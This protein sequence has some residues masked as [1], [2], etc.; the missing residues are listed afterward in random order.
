LNFKQVVLSPLISCCCILV[1]AAAVSVVPHSNYSLQIIHNGELIVLMSWD[2]R[3]VCAAA[4]AAA[5]AGLRF[6][7]LIQQQMLAIL[8]ACMDRLCAVRG[9]VSHNR[10]ALLLFLAVV[11]G[12]WI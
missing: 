12:G 4:A 5:E 8:G 9:C 7:F 1:V 2:I 6:L 10:I 11:V 3:R